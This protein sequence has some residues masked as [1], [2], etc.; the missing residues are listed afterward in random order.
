[1]GCLATAAVFLFIAYVLHFT[2]RRGVGPGREPPDQGWPVRTF[3]GAMARAW[4][5]RAQAAPTQLRPPGAPDSGLPLPCMH[6]AQKKKA[7]T[8]AAHAQAA[9]AGWPWRPCTPSPGR[10]S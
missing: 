9:R 2:C 7:R 8:P 6:D 1:M 10:W 5:G 4:P 3:R